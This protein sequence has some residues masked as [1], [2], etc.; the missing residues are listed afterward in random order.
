MKTLINKISKHLPFLFLLAVAVFVFAVV[1]RMNYTRY[2]NFE[3][4]KFD[5]GNMVQMVWNTMNGRF[6]YLTDY[7]GMNMPRWGM[8]HVDPLLIIFVPFMAIFK[9]PLVLTFSQSAFVIFSSLILYKIA[10]LELKNKFVAMLIGLSYLLYPAIGWILAWTDYHGVTAAIPFFLGSFYVYERMHKAGD[11]SLKNKVILWI[12]LVLSMAGKEEI[13]LFVSLMGVF[14]LI[15]RTNILSYCDGWVNC[16]ENFK[17]FIALEPAKLAIKIMIVSLAWFIFA[18]FILIPS[19]AHYRV[20]SYSAFA[21]SIGIEDLT[22]REVTQENY[23]LLRYEKFGDTY[24]EVIFGMLTHPKELMRAWTDG[25]KPIFFRQTFDPLLFFPLLHPAT[26]M[27]AIPEFVINYSSTAGGVSTAN[28]ENHRISLIIAVMFIS[29]IY[30]LSFTA[31]LLKSY[32]KIN[33]NITLVVMALALFAANYTKTFEYGN[34][35]YLWIKQSL[36]RRIVPLVNAEENRIDD[37]RA[38]NKDLA[39]GESLKLVRLERYDRDCA[40]L[41]VESVKPEQSVTGPDYMGAKLSMRETYALFP[42]LYNQADVV[43]ADVYARKIS[44]VLQVP[45]IIVNSSMG[46]V[47]MDPNYALKFVCGNMAVFERGGPYEKTNILPIQQVFDYTPTMD[48]EIYRG[49]HLRDFAL[50][51][52]IDR[53]QFYKANFVYDIQGTNNL[54]AHKLFLTFVNKETAEYFQFPHLPSYSMVP[55]KDWSKNRFY[56]E[57][58]DI[59]LPEFLEDNTYRVFIGLTDGIDTRSVYIGEVEVN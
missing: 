40:Q 19:A 32:L 24:A 17:R 38:F 50:P 5:L 51:Q 6:M 18:F 14:I 31:K 55:I 46:K 52:V 43:I 59:M 21:K 15:F 16:K 53:G 25:S 8:S 26:F 11:Y 49:L 13:P 48:S 9:T 35:V 12:L 54:D 22:T 30:G 29:T 20:D 42:A 58:V 7:F 37:D 34:P 4:G 3:N 10:E 33:T 27:M 39:I 41:I 23:F 1:L 57:E 2:D 47:M 36:E 56:T 28:I 45:S 44:S